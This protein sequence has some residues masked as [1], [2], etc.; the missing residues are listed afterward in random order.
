MASFVQPDPVPF[1]LVSL[2]DYLPLVGEE[3]VERIAG[4]ARRLRDL[5]VVNVNSTYHGGG[6]AE[7]LSSLTLLV[8]A[9][10]IRTGWRVIQG[11]PDFFS[12]TK[13]FHNA[14][15]GAEINF[16]E[17]ER[18]IYEEVVFE[19]AQRMHFDHDV[20][21]VHDPQ[22]LPLVRHYRWKSPWIWGCHTSISR[23]PTPKS[24]TV[25]GRSS[26]ATTSP[27]CTSPS[28]RSACVSRSASSCRPSTLSAPRTARW[29]RRRSASGWSITASRPIFRS[30]CRSRASTASRSRRA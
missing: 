10:G 27:S 3:T 4:N 22:P 12:I 18:S 2:D 28:R 23:H 15:Q 29:A 26:S 25:C 19:N 6:V 21:I 16:T 30:S 1:R 17:L 7:L 13:K 9:C 5:H 11:R 14:L 8:N 24:G 20:V